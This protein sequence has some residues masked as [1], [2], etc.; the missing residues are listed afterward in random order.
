ME[1]NHFDIFL[2][3]TAFFGSILTYSSIVKIAMGQYTTVSLA[4]RHV[5]SVSFTGYAFS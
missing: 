5:L 3:I 2:K 4:Y 1:V